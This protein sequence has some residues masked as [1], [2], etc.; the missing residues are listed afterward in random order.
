M[1]LIAILAVAERIAKVV[2]I[3]AAVLPKKAVASV[4]TIETAAGEL[5]ALLGECGATIADLKSARYDIDYTRNRND[6][7]IRDGE[8]VANL[9]LEPGQIKALD[10][11]LDAL[12]RGFGGALSQIVGP[13]A[14]RP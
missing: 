4:E 11:L 2:P 5:S 14:P 9:V 8:P 6:A 3:L 12:G 13:E 1:S 7:A 10:V